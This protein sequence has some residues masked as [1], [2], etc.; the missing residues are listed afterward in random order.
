MHTILY[1]K[2][3]QGLASSVVRSLRGWLRKVRSERSGMN[4]YTEPTKLTVHSESFCNNVKA[5]Y[6]KD[7]EHGKC[8][9]I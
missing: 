7:D 4:E 1:L 2:Q 9:M 5:P 6:Q 8:L 3:L